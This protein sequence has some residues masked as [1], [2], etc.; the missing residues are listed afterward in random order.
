MVKSMFA[1][2]AGLRTHQSRM[3]VTGNNISNVNTWGYK[4]ATMSFKDAMYQTTSS[5]GK[6]STENGGY[7][8]TNANQIGYGVGTGVISYD[9]STGG[10]SPSSR[11]LDC[12]IDGTGFFIVGPMLSDGSIALDG[13]D[14]IKSSGLYLSR[15]GQF[16]VDN[17]GY[18]TDDSGNYVYGFVSNDISKGDGFNTTSLQPLKIPTTE[19]MASVS[20]KNASSATQ[21][22]KKAYEE[23]LALLNSLNATLGT[24]R[25]EYQAAKAAYDTKATALGLSTLE[26]GVTDAQK[27]MEKAYADWVDNP[28]DATLKTTYQNAKLAYDEANFKLTKAQAELRAD[29][30]LASNQPAL[31]NAW[32][33]YKT[34]YNDYNADPT[35]AAKKTAL[36]TKLAELERLENAV[37]KIEDTSLEGKLNAAKQAVDAAS[38]KATAQEKTVENAKKTL[39]TAQNSA[40]STQVSNASAS[41]DELAQLE[42]YKIQ[43]DG[44]LTATTKEGVTVT[45]GKIALAAVHNT[46]GLVKD[47]G[48]YYSISDNAGAVSVYEAGGTAGRILGN[49]LEMSTVDLA[50]EMTTM[51]TT[52]R[53]F[54]ANSKIIT[55]TDQMLEELVNMKR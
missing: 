36:D 40:T 27:A 15:V 6:G 17:N 29:Q 55:V 20:N 32:T 31:D 46:N 51:I 34:A 53:G 25:T 28:S 41:K 43:T 22:A 7:G 1:G 42:S 11:S 13:D 8:G 54:Q 37:T 21:T 39:E 10:M 33:A 24:A 49:Y 5:G 3:D 12:M 18:L 4:S 47:T 35:D 45:I 30:A 14:A 48:Y 52:Q 44:S 26:T 38:A 2:V 50:T 16:Y 9:F 23:A 19:D